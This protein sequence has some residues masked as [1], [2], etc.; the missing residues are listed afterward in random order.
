VLG[1]EEFV[2]PPL[3]LA[4][5]LEKEYPFAEVTFHATTRSPILPSAEPDYPF[6]IRYQLRSLY[7]EARTTYVYNL[8]Q[9]D[10]VF[11][12]HDAPRASETGLNDLYG[13]LFETGCRN[14]QVI[15]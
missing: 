10:Q 8:M 6:F 7:D 3:M 13:A 2:Y 15:Q 11:V 5:C 14:I 9:Y 1:T 4:H 12:F